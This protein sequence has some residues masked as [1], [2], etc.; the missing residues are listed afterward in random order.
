MDQFFEPP[1]VKGIKGIDTNAHAY[2]P[3][4]QQGMDVSMPRGV[5][6]KPRKSDGENVIR[7]ASHP[8][9]QIKGNTMFDTNDNHMDVEFEVKKLKD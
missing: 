5:V 3:F 2:D 4:Q 6:G 7:T 1:Y 9:P 8:G